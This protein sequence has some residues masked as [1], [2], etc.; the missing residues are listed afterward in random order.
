MRT[1]LARLGVAVGLIA[2]VG[3]PTPPAHAETTFTTVVMAS[4]TLDGGFGY[5]ILT[6]PPTPNFLLPPTWNALQTGAHL[7]GGRHNPNT[8]L[9]LNDGIPEDGFT[10]CHWTFDHKRK[11]NLQQIICFNATKNVNKLDKAPLHL[12]ACSFALIDVTKP[13]A[14]TASGHCGVSSGQVTVLFTDALEQD[15]IIDLHF[16]AISG[17]V[18]LWGHYIK[19]SATIGQHGKVTGSV[20]VLPPDPVTTPNQSCT[21]KTARDFLVAGT[22]V[23]IPSPA[24]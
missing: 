3:M 18:T 14:N 13:E 21:N 15:F 6:L 7:L 22:T 2:A 9:P 12:G 17:V 4:L 23:G 1:H 8:C 11:I 24:L 10:N 19:L 16:K 20:V 5:P